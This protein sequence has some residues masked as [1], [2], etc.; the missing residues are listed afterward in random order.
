M[1]QTL[2]RYTMSLNQKD[3][4]WSGNSL[5]LQLRK[6][7]RHS[8]QL[9]KIMLT[10]FWDMKGPITTDIY[11]KGVTVNSVSYCQLLWKN[12]AQLLGAVEY[13]DCISAEE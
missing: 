8:G 7:S 9:K 10:I 4:P 13:T 6:S 3:N 1:S 12:F 2:G 11:E 5:T